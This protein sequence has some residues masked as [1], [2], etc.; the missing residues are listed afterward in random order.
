M[1]N[2]NPNTNSNTVPSAYYTLPPPE[3][4]PAVTNSSGG[5]SVPSAYYTLPPPETLPAVTNSSAGAVVPAQ[6]EEEVPMRDFNQW[7]N[8]Y[9]DEDDGLYDNDVYVKYNFLW[10][11]NQQVCSV[12][13]P[14]DQFMTSVHAFVD[15]LPKEGCRADVLEMCWHAMMS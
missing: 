10:V 7:L 5:S 2:S 4:L 11:L 3:T 15:T 12:D 13:L 1:T 9:E 6:T 14:Q 8:D